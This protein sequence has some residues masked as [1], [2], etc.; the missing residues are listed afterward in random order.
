[1]K[2]ML[3]IMSSLLSAIAAETQTMPVDGR[4]ELMELPYAENALEPVI[5]AETIGLHHGKHLLGYVTALNRLIAG[6]D[7]AD[8]SLEEIVAA[9]DGAVFNN[10][11]QTLNHNLYFTQFSPDGGGEPRGALRKAIDASWGSFDRF[12]KDFVDAGTSLFGSG[13][14]WL[15]ADKSGDLTIVKEPNGGNPVAR[16]LVPLLG[17]DVWEHAYYLDYNNRRADH[18]NALWRIVDWNTVEKRYDN[19]NQ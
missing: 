12:K 1:M 17:F 14:V 19:L 4:F 9:S 15:A 10:A 16:G 8:R 11:G 2:R 7:L 6:T 18:L 5:S 13:W 3:L